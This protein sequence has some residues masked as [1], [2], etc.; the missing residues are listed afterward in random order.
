LSVA[1]RHT[2]SDEDLAALIESMRLGLEGGPEIY[3]PGEFWGELLARNLAMIRSDGIENLKRN[4]ANNYYNWIVTSVFDPQVK[5]AVRR[6][7]QNPSLAPLTS[8]IELRPTGLRSLDR[9]DVYSLSRSAAWRY[10]FFVGGA[11]EVARQE[12]RDGLTERLAEPEVGNPIRIERGGRLIS[13]DLANSIIEYSFASRSGVVS[14]GARVAELGAG[15]GRLA[16]VYANARD[17]TYCIF[18]I[19]PALAVAQWYLT[20]VLGADRIVPYSQKDRLP[21]LGPGVVAFFTPD[22]LELFPHGWFDL[23]QTISTLP[24]MPAR[25]SSHYLRTLADKASGAVFLKQ[26]RQWRNEADEVDLRESDYRLPAPWALAE[27]RIDPIQPAFFNQ[28]WL[29]G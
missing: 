5:L 6:W 1:P 27:R 26:W 22:Q 3:Q 16:Y 2:S 15:Y 20:R 28:L 21:E 11:W 24:E 10:K 19:P 4:V 25:Q 7:L 9:D 29:R 17:L 14:D 18:D 13:Q 8:R 12:D 23:T